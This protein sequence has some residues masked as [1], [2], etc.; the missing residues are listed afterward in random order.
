M[1]I[2]IDAWNFCSGPASNPSSPEPNMQTRR[3]SLDQIHIPSP[4]EADWD[5]MTGNAA[6]RYCSA[7]E[8][9]V[10]DLSTMSRAAAEKL[11]AGGNVCV[12]LTLGPDGRPVTHDPVRAWWKPARWAAA[13]S[14]LISGTLAMASVSRDAHTGRNEKVALP[15]MVPVVQLGK[16]GGEAVMVM[17]DVSAP[18]TQPTTQPAP[19]DLRCVP[20]ADDPAAT[21]QPE[22]R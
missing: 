22:G 2:E 19:P 15:G 16:I 5:A 13:A 4:C 21:T 8:K 12:R 17:G 20:N 18:A 7:C 14:L 10:H 3:L 6:R 1:S 11:V 9:H